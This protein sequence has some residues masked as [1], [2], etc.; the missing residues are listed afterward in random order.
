MPVP[1]L[2]P[3]TVP[4]PVL[5]LGTELVLEPVQMP[6]PVPVSNPAPVPETGSLA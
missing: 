1:V 3:E 5:E 4:V 2:E 6:E